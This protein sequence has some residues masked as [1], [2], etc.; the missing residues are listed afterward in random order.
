MYT[1]NTVK[2]FINEMNDQVEDLIK[3]CKLTSSHIVIAIMKVVYMYT[4]IKRDAKHIYVYPPDKLNQPLKETT[5]AYCLAFKNDC[6]D[7][8]YNTLVPVH[9]HNGIFGINTWLRCYFNDVHLICTTDDPHQLHDGRVSAHTLENIEHDIE[10]SYSVMSVRTL[11][12]LAI[13]DKLSNLYEEAI[14]E[15]DKLSILIIFY[16]L[17]EYIWLYKYEDK[18]HTAFT[19]FVKFLKEDKRYMGKYVSKEY[20]IPDHGGM[21]LFEGMRTSE[22]VHT[23]EVMKIIEKIVK[24]LSGIFSRRNECGLLQMKFEKD[25]TDAFGYYMYDDRE[26]FWMNNR[27]SWKDYALSWGLADIK[28]PLTYAN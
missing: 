23:G 8:K 10:H 7:L 21:S 1:E 13:Y 20:A 5:H 28:Y 14:I 11:P 25:I 12:N 24:F 3:E 6:I 26:K 4:N 19:G 9:A 2:I 18:I 16:V 27:K 17:H 22:T 15:G